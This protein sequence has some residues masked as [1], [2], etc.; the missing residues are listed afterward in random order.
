MGGASR[1]AA[2]ADVEGAVDLG[3]LTASFFFRRSWYLFFNREKRMRELG[4]K[5]AT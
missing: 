2:G 4:E 1:P 3:S 5:G